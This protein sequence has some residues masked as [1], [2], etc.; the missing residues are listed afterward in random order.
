M[1]GGSTILA[2]VGKNLIR[3]ILSF[4]RI[5]YI[6]VYFSHLHGPYRKENS[7]KTSGVSWNQWRGWNVSMKYVTMMLRPKIENLNS[8][9]LVE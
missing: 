8:S 7:S 5:I 4:Q 2:I 3:Y 1:D 6:F 9:S